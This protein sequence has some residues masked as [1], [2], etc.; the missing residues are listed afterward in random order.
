MRG[1][2]LILS[3][4]LTAVCLSKAQPPMKQGE[5]GPLKKIE[6][7]EK[8]KLIETLG[9]DEQTTLKFFARRAKYREEER[10]LFE[11]SGA[12]LDKM[13]EI[14]KG[15]D[16]KNNDDELKKLI[17]QYLDNENKILSKRIEFYNSLNDILNY[18]QISELMVFEKKFR[19]E[20]RS[21]LFKE[22]RKMP[23]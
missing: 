3:F 12:L 2:I 4:V 18:K 14:S 16:I 5:P 10:K 21:A 20:I 23:R 9:M 1:I 8:I 11:N 6:D 7:L 19:E 17:D 22:R 15:N 13:E